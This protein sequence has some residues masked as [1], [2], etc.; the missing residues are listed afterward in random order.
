METL[1]AA[2]EASSDSILDHP[3]WRPTLPS[4]NGT[5]FSMP[6]LIAMAGHPNPLAP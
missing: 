3:G 2:I 1:H 6:D 5:Y 4:T